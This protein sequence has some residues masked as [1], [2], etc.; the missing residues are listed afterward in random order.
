MTVVDTAKLA[1]LTEIYANAVKDLT[2]LRNRL[3]D[4][5]E[6]LP[7]FEPSAKYLISSVRREILHLLDAA[8]SDDS[9]IDVWIRLEGDSLADGRAPLSVLGVYLNSVA[10]ANKH[11]VSIAKK[12]DHHGRRF[13]REVT[14]VAEFSL[15]RTAPGSVKVG[16]MRPDPSKF[17]ATL[18]D[19]GQQSPFPSMFLESLVRANEESAIAIDGFRLLART[20]E[21]AQGN[22]E[23]DRLCADVG[24]YNTLRLLH[25]AQSLAPTRKG[26]INTVSIYGKGLERTEEQRILMTRE[27]QEELK[28]CA[29]V[30]LDDRKM[31]QARGRIRAV[32]IDRRKFIARPLCLEDT[33]EFY[34]ELECRLPDDMDES[35]IKAILDKPVYISGTA[36]LSETGELRCIEVLDVECNCMSE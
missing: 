31:A 12:M 30:L 24:Q 8:Y 29:T 21:V 23:L 3:A 15:V 6:L 17:I 19:Q 27:T 20:V 2:D 34:T 22:Q 25:Q 36:V 33:D 14:D 11:A 9:D 18:P 13:A 32:D 26:S 4:D 1:R 16:L 7:V 35:Y 10:V 28:R 5:P